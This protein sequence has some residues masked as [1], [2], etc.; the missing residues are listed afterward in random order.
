MPK[1]VQDERTKQELRRKL[2]EDVADF[3]KSGGEIQQIPT[4]H[5]G[6][7]MTKSGAKHIKLGNRK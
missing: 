6:V 7:D 4:G 5:S 1:K 3:L 2:E